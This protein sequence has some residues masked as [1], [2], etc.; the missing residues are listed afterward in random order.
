MKA[1]RFFP[2]RVGCVALTILIAGFALA[3]AGDEPA[4]SALESDP[5]G[6]VDILPTAD[7]KGWVR[8]PVKTGVKL[9]RAQWHV[10]NGLLVCDGNGGHDMFLLDHE[11]GDAIFHVE[12]CFVKIP[13]PKSYNS[14]VFVRTSLDGATWHQAQT[15]SLSGGNLFGV[16]P[17]PAGPK[18]FDVSTQPCRVKEAGEWNTYEVTAQGPKLTLWVNGYVTAVFPDCGLPKGYLGLEGEGYRIQFRN[19]KL[20]ELP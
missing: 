15:G 6:W 5:R 18:K 20:K 10:E 3:R 8:V 11:V 9:K 19:L 2:R 14:G 13:N 7:L 12:F 1:C 4:K 16:T 17:S